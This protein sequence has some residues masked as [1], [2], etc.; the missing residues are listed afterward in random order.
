MADNRGSEESNQADSSQIPHRDAAMDVA[1]QRRQQK[2]EMFRP[3]KQMRATG[4]K[5]SQTARQ[6]G[7]CQHRQMDPAQRPTGKEPAAVAQAALGGGLSAWAHAIRRRFGSSAM[8][9]ATRDSPNS[10][11]RGV[12][13]KQTPEER[14]PGFPTLHNLQVTGSRQ[15]SSQVAAAL[16]SKVR[17]ELTGQQAQIV[18]TLKRQCPTF[19]VMRKL[20]FGIRA[21]LR[22]GQGDN[23]PPPDGR[24]ARGVHH[25][26]VLCGL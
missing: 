14:S 24:S 1:R 17:A 18:D 20:V 8:S 19:A 3:I 15:L 12:S 7:L 21:I 5:V 22:G 10:F 9:V 13:Q 6:L 4:M 11:R 16:L 26:S 23:P 2:P 25:W